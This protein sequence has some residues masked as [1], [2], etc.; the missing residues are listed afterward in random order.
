MFAA[1][2]SIYVFF[3][4]DEDYDCNQDLY[5][6]KDGVWTCQQFKDKRFA[7]KLRNHSTTVVPLED[8]L[9][10]YMLGGSNNKKMYILE[11]EDNSLR[12]AF[13]YLHLIRETAIYYLVGIYTSEEVV[14]LLVWSFYIWY[15]IFDILCCVWVI[16]Y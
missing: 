16:K 10:V 7:K 8:K 9:R 4:S 12:R 2:E 15:F 1:N 5:G 14:D 6:Y 3:G 13:E 11:L